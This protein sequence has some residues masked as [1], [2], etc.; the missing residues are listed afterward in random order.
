MGPGPVVQHVGGQDGPWLFLFPCSQV[1]CLLF[2]LTGGWGPDYDKQGRSG[3]MVTVIYKTATADCFD[4][5]EAAAMALRAAC[6][7]IPNTRLHT[8]QPLDLLPLAANPGLYFPIEYFSN[9]SG[10]SIRVWKNNSAYCPFVL[11]GRVNLCYSARHLSI[12]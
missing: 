3:A 10:K 11:Y 12:P 7:G 2:F 5:G 8:H 1:R 4:S 9:T 6:S